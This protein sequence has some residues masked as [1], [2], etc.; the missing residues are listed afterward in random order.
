[1]VRQG[2][3]NGLS[4]Y[5][6]HN[7]PPHHLQRDEADR[8]PRVAVWRRPADQRDDRRL[9]DAVELLLTAWS[10]VVRERGRQPTLEVPLQHPADLPVVP[11]D[12]GG[13]G[14]DREPCVEVLERQDS[15]PSPRG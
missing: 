15:P 5:P 4:A 9:L 11:A 12:C 3:P 1:V 6:L 2:H 8:P 10:C 14:A 13:R 7:A